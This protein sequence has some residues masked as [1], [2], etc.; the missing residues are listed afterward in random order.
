VG[1]WKR[2]VKNFGVIFDEFLCDTMSLDVLM[3]ESVWRVVHKYMGYMLIAFIALMTVGGYA[4]GSFS[5]LENFEYVHFVE[6]E[7]DTTFVSCDMLEDLL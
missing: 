7:L 2:D 3:A 4:M 6:L 1:G 5:A